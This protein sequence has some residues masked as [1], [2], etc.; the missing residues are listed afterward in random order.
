MCMYKTSQEQGQGTSSPKQ[1]KRVE[2]GLV[3]SEGPSPIRMEF[4]ESTSPGE[5]LR[6]LFT[7]VAPF[8]MYTFPMGWF[9]QPLWLHFESSM[10]TPSILISSFG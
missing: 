6:L 1:K 2:R 8:T 4:S 7:S 5:V 3:L 9:I 10:F